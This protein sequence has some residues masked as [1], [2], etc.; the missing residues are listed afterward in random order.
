MLRQCTTSNLEHNWT[1]SLPEA[2]PLKTGSRPDGI[3]AVCGNGCR[4]LLPVPLV[5]LQSQVRW[6]FIPKWLPCEHSKDV[7]G[8]V[9]VPVSRVPAAVDAF[10]TQT[11]LAFD[12]SLAVF[13]FVVR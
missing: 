2:Y 4:G 5:C 12:A 3:D 7:G 8:S 1:D 6:S 13:S 9:L 10:D 11:E